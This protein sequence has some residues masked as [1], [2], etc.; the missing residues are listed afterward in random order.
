MEGVGIVFRSIQ[1]VC[2]HIQ[3]KAV[4]QF[5]MCYLNLIYPPST[6]K[7]IYNDSFQESCCLFNVCVLVFC[8]GYNDVGVGGWGVVSLICLRPATGVIY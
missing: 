5:Y 6:A 2:C 3:S 7:A 8:G 4:V 1:F